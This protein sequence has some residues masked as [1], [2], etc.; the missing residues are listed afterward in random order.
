MASA[1]ELSQIVHRLETV[2]SKLESTVLGA[3]GSTAMPGKKK[4][5][6]FLFFV[7]I[8][9]LHLEQYM[10]TVGQLSFI[11]IAWKEAQN[12]NEV[13]PNIWH[14]FSN[15][16]LTSKI[17]STV[18]LHRPSSVLVP[19]LFDVLPLKDKQFNDPNKLLCL[20]HLKRP[21]FY[22]KRLD[23]PIFQVGWKT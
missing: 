21:S 12:E 4:K 7:W 18:S 19:R 3:K 16:R 22:S 10:H 13:T 17:G 23:W 11:F 5:T 2:A 15:G 9:Q 14:V 1:A 6:S 20:F 8:C